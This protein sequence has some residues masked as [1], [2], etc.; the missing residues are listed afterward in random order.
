MG[1]PWV[2]YRFP[3][4]LL[5]VSDNNNIFVISKNIYINHSNICW[6]SLG[7]RKILYCVSF[8]KYCYI[9]WS[10]CRTLQTNKKRTCSQKCI[11]LKKVSTAAAFQQL[12]SSFS[13]AFQ[14]LLNASTASYLPNVTKYFFLDR[15]SSRSF[16]IYG[17]KMC[18]RFI[19]LT[20]M[21]LEG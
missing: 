4:G 18:S 2:S 20:L 5:W 8:R 12:F 14:H 7:E 19:T 6:M 17:R 21:L 9:Y 10:E 16:S 1:L 11:Q 13:A 15:I 3:M